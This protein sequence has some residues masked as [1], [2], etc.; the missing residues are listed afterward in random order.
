MRFYEK[1]HVNSEEGFKKHNRL[2]K[3][4]P[5]RLDENNKTA[6]D[7][8]YQKEF[9]VPLDVL[10]SNMEKNLEVTTNAIEPIFKMPL[11]RQY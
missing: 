11:I 7:L 4:H 8:D 3:A 6:S 2:R 5:K 1:N 10:I 9:K